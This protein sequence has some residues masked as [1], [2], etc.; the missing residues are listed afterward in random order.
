MGIPQPVDIKK[1]K[2]RLITPSAL[3]QI[4]IKTEMGKSMDSENIVQDGQQEKVAHKIETVE[5]N[6]DAKKSSEATEEETNA[7]E[8]VVKPKQTSDDPLNFNDITDENDEKNEKS[9]KSS[10][11]SD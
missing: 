4:S 10:P 11:H 7:G 1:E 9:N 8:E 3:G 6:G 2:V 5:N